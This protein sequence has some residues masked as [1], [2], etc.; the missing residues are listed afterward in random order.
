MSSSK[1]RSYKVG[2]LRLVD[3]TPQVLRATRNRPAIRVSVNPI[4][5]PHRQGVPML[6]V[7][8]AIWNACQMA[9][10]PQSVDTIGEAK[11][12]TSRSGGTRPAEMCLNLAELCGDEVLFQEMHKP[13]WSDHT[14]Q[15]A[16]H[17][18][19]THGWR[20]AVIVTRTP[21]HGFAIH[22]SESGQLVHLVDNGGW[23]A[24]SIAGWR[25]ANIEGIYCLCRRVPPDERVAPE[26][27]PPQT[28]TGQGVLF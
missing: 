4:P 26:L 12:M 16:V 22:I 15:E 21:G 24:G 27:P 19:W 28:A 18:L 23:P 7:P 5:R 25:G 11:R 20:T 13:D 10:V 8:T 2:G 14:L 9:G 17:G 1:Q 6:C 3:Q